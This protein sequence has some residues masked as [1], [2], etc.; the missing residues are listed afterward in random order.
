MEPGLD[1][2]VRCASRQLHGPRRGAV[3]RGTTRQDRRAG[4]YAVICFRAGAWPSSWISIFFGAASWDAGIVISSMPL[5]CVA[6]T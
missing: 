1:A 4:P 2:K 5:T 6:C 3:G